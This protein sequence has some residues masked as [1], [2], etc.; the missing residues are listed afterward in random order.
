M[1]KLGKNTAKI[2]FITKRGEAR[3]NRIDASTYN[4]I[5]DM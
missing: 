1:S 5:E 4:N 3:D 2:E